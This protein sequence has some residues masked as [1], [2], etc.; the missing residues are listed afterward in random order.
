M[1]AASASLPSTPLRRNDP[2]WERLPSQERLPTSSP[3]SP[4]SRTRARHNSIDGSTLADHNP[5][6][7]WFERVVTLSIPD[8]VAPA[9]ALLSPE[10]DEEE[11]HHCDDEVLDATERLQRLVMLCSL[12]EARVDEVLRAAADC[13]SSRMLEHAARGD[14]SATL[15]DPLPRAA[16]VALAAYVA[17]PAVA[18]QLSSLPSDSARAHIL[19]LIASLDNVTEASTAAAGTSLGSNESSPVDS[20][21]PTLLIDLSGEVGEVRSAE[22]GDRNGERRW[23]ESDSSSGRDEQSEGAE[24]V[25]DDEHADTA[26][27]QTRVGAE[28]ERRWEDTRMVGLPW[29]PPSSPSKKGAAL[30]DDG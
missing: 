15:A 17:R 14:Y 19:S 18:Q 6:F 7:D 5:L 3:S 1:R 16:L 27:R 12:E 20:A 8:E 25:S 30:H 9:R 21:A 11:D 22:S 10:E 23:E 4:V 29:T 13:Y 2:Q 28:A 26:P 24:A